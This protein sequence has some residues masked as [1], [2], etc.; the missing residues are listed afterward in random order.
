MEVRQSKQRVASEMVFSF[1]S[2]GSRITAIYSLLT[3]SSVNPF[4]ASS[5][6]IIVFVTLVYRFGMFCIWY[7]ID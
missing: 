1:I 6:R 2:G 3:L 7:C 5:V 4:Q